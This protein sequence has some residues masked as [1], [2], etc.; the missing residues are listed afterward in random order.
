MSITAP[1]A[2]RTVSNFIDGEER[3]AASGATFDKL[4]PATGE[5]ISHVA[6]STAEDVLVGETLIPRGTTVVVLLAAANRDP[7]QY[8]EAD[9]LDLT[10]TENKHVGFGY[11]IHYCLG[12][13]LA[14]LEARIAFNTLL[15]RLP[16]LRLAVPATQLQYTQGTI[17]RGLK[18][19]PVRWDKA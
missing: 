14:R 7:E 3:P 4:S 2:T 18:R 1:S 10:R 12:A 16:S 17:G 13:P 8:P 19:L 6:R 9:A 5:V 15:A 11:G